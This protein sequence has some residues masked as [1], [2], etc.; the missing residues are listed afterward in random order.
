MRA[1]KAGVELGVFLVLA[2]C[3]IAISMCQHARG[4]ST[5][6]STLTL[7]PQF[8]MGRAKADTC[9]GYWI[10]PVVKHD[11]GTEPTEDDKAKALWAAFKNLRHDA[12]QDQRK[13]RLGKG[14]GRRCKHAYPIKIEVNGELLLE[15]EQVW[16]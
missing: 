6:V 7:T 10:M 13:M 16:R 12:E 4:A 14:W 1:A 9:Y 5:D 8:S 15:I 2:A 3:L 11:D